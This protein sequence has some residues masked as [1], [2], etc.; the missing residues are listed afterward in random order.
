MLK[1]V[2]KVMIVPVVLISLASPVWAGGLGI[3]L[4]PSP[5]P[6]GGGA[7][8]YQLYTEGPFTVSW[9]PCTT[10]NP[11]NPPPYG[12]LPTGSLLIGDV[13]CLGFVNDTG[14]DISSLTLQFTVTSALNGLTLTCSNDP[15]DTYLAANNCSSYGTL[16]T[17]EFV[18]LTFNAPV[19]VPPNYDFYFGVTST[20]PLTLSDIPDTGL[21][22][23]TYDPSTL[24]LLA[25][26]M[27]FLAMGTL[28]RTA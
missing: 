1:Q 5:A 19:D 8:D 18:S 10:S 15:G 17:G 23:P 14:A 22:L 21:S 13:A 20:A 4:D 16:S 12:P 26:G 6:P 7:N 11:S 25:T 3:T 27:A 24:M 9:Q 2:L 28:R